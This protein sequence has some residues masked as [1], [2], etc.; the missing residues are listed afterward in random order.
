MHLYSIRTEK[1]GYTFD[2]FFFDCL[3]KVQISKS[4]LLSIVYA[5]HIDKKYFWL[6]NFNFHQGFKK[7]I[8]TVV[9]SITILS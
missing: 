5:I 1:Y 4:N 2:D 8:S 3:T 6:K 9:N 7:N